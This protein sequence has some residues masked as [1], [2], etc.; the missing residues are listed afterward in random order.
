MLSISGRRRI[1]LEN[2]R[3]PPPHSAKTG[4][5]GAEE[6]DDDDGG[7]SSGGVAPR[8]MQDIVK[9]W[10]LFNNEIHASGGGIAAELSG[11]GGGNEGWDTIPHPSCVRDRLAQSVA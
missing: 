4:V 2:D 3:G 1:R 10:W 9:G 5:R 7:G 8:T 11:E 6:G